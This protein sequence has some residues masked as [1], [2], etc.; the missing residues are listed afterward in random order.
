[1]NHACSNEVHRHK[2]TACDEA[3]V[4]SA[5]FICIICIG[6]SKDERQVTNFRSIVI[7][8]LFCIQLLVNI[9]Q[10]DMVWYLPKYVWCVSVYVVCMISVQCM[11]LCGLYD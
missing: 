5:P 7:W 3:A 2:R 1:M 8:F 11:C 9:Q 10:A 6:S 4:S